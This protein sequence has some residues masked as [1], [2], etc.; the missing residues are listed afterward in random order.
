MLKKGIKKEKQQRLREFDADAGSAFVAI[1]RWWV[2]F[3][4]TCL[5]CTANG[6]LEFALEFNLAFAAAITVAELLV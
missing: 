4:L 2:R 5:F 6:F 1:V 3:V